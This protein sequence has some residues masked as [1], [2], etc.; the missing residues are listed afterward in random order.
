MHINELN[1]ANSKL[2]LLESRAVADHS[3]VVK[4]RELQQQ[5]NQEKLKTQW[6]NNANRESAVE[7]NTGSGNS[8]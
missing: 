4:A 6:N 3:K 1:E 7:K 2:S 5:E 8:L